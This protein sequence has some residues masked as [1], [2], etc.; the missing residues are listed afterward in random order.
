MRRSIIAEGWSLTQLETPY[1]RLD[2][3]T[4]RSLDAPDRVWYPV[5]AMPAQVHDILHRN[6]IIEEPWL[7]GR[8]EEC[9][10]VGR[11]DWVYRTSFELGGGRALLGSRAAQGIPVRYLLTFPGLD[12]IADIYVDDN[13]VGECRNEFI[14]HRIDITRVVRPSHMV[15]GITTNHE[16][17]IHF[18]SAWK[19]MEDQPVPEGWYGE[20]DRTAVIRKMGNDFREYLGQKPHF[21]RVGVFRDIFLEE[22]A[23]IDVTDW[24]TTA[25]LSSDLQEGRIEC[26]FTG[27]TMM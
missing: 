22:V 6:G 15:G 19:Y 25:R 9:Q 7:P 26:E 3:E 24:R 11:Q 5:G 20:L 1:E 13:L 23:G 10:W 27:S 12:T 2:D 14:S 16:L 17:V 18:K 4:L 21:V 8:A